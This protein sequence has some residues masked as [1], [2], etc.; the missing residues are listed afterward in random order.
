MDCQF[1]SLYYKDK[2]IAALVKE[3][4]YKGHGKEIVLLTLK[5]M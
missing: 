3:H 2:S 4:V 5:S 1:G